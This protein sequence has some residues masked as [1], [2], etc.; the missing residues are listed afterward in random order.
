MEAI[1]KGDLKFLGLDKPEFEKFRE[2]AGK[3]KD[4]V[5]VLGMGRVGERIANKVNPF[6]VTPVYSAFL[7][8]V[9]LTVENGALF[10]A[11]PIWEDVEFAYIVKSAGLKSL[12]VQRLYHG[13]V[14]KRGQKKIDEPP[15]PLQILDIDPKKMSLSY[16]D[17]DVDYPTLNTLMDHFAEKG[18][19][20][21]FQTNFI[22]TNNLETMG[23]PPGR[24][25]LLDHFP[26][27]K[28]EEGE[29]AVVFMSL[30]FTEDGEVLIGK[31]NRQEIVL[32]ILKCMKYRLSEFWIVLPLFCIDEDDWSDLDVGKK[33]GYECT[34]R[35]LDFNQNYDEPMIQI[36]FNVE[37]GSIPVQRRSGEHGGALIFQ[38]KAKKQV[39]EELSQL[40]Q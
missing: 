9:T 8:N 20:Q 5:G 17:E 25:Q 28:F 18:C 11:K 14:W 3:L 38:F 15:V 23:I 26:G 36:S 21:L 39:F 1:M 6:K 35:N 31:L 33:V 32:T 16:T 40:S 7:M 10:P 4:Q 24:L 13:K 29:R 2:G 27:C 37:G 19:K 22:Q 30:H 34:R 12:K